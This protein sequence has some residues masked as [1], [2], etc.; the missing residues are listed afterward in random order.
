MQ[1]LAGI[2]INRTTV[3]Y[4]A[5]NNQQILIIQKRLTHQCQSFFYE[6]FFL[7]CNLFQSYRGRIRQIL[8]IPKVIHSS[9]TFTLHNFIRRFSIVF[10]VFE[11][12]K[13][14]RTVYHLLILSQRLNRTKLCSLSCRI[15]SK[16]QSNTGRK[17]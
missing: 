5:I 9:P 10:N 1:I 13:P 15:D 17:Q 4:Q 16:E 14:L 2:R 7:Q 3:N 8:I 6:L 12:C 11:A